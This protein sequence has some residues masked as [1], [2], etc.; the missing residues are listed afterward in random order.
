MG[1]GVLAALSLG[2]SGPPAGAVAGIRFADLPRKG[3][4]RITTSAYQLVLD[5]KNG[6]ILSLVDRAAKKQLVVGQGGCMWGARAEGGTE[7]IGGCSFS[8]KGSRRFSYRWDPRSARLTL[9]YTRSSVTA[10]AVVSASTNYFDVV[11]TVTNP[12]HKVLTSMLVPDDLAGKS[13]DV[14]AGYSPTFLPGIRI[15]PSFFKTTKINIYNYPGRYIWAD[16][17]AFDEGTGHLALY[18]VNPDPSPI[19]PVEMGFVRTQPGSFCGDSHFCITHYF[20]TQISDGATWTSPLVRI[21]I[22]ETV[23]KTLRDYRTDN[24]I[25]DWPSVADKLGAKAQQYERSPL[26]KADLRKNLPPFAQWGSQLHRL[27]SPVLLHPVRYQ[28]GSFDEFAPD[29]LPPDPSVGTMADLRTMITHAHEHGDLVMPYLNLSWWNPSSPTVH[30]LLADGGPAQFAALKK[31][32]TPQTVTY[33]PFSGYVVSAYTNAAQDRIHDLMDQ[34]QQ[35]APTDCYFIDQLGARPWLRDYNPAAPDSL[36]YYD[37]WLKLMAPYASRC[38][39]VE[40]GWDRLAKIFAGF[41][42]GLLDVQRETAEADKVFGPGNWEPYP[43]A[44]YIFH[45][46]VLMYQH[47][48][49]EQTMT[50]DPYTLT[51]NLAYGFMLSYTWDGTTDSLESP[52]LDVVGSFQHALGALYAGQP[53]Q[54]FRSVGANQTVTEFP[55]LTVTADWNGSSPGFLAQAK[56]DSVTA[57]SVTGT[58]DGSALSPGTHDLIVT[59]TNGEVTVHQPLG[60]DTPLSVRVPAS[61]AAGSAVH[62]TWLGADGLTHTVGGT[63]QGGRFTFTCAGPQPGLPAPTYHLTRG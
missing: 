17:L 36:S 25:D 53:L 34:W 10:T 63:V 49:A 19:R 42:G 45:D 12:L 9:K 4:L 22:G 59:R 29:F 40:D 60:A 8:P 58:F 1:L 56:D 54:D 18:S 21:R 39:M 38:L 33:P 6:A 23:D 3:Q 7:Y 32:G 24:G 50:T 15:P 2:I 20:D 37:G 41:H 11:V 30:R 27:P 62:A 43:M 13:A 16:Y 44:E 5:R 28:P 46:K 26:V 61:W 35:Q 51:F 48:L 55:N 14:T 52:W 47:D 31:D 57:G